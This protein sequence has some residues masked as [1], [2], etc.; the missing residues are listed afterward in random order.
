[1]RCHFYPP[2]IILLL[3]QY[4]LCDVEES[5]EVSK[6]QYLVRNIARRI[7][8]TPQEKSVSP[9]PGDTC[10]SEKKPTLLG[11]DELMVI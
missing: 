2:S 1:M 3:K 4:S 11:K 9:C 6:W 10:F 7:F 5:D 8:D